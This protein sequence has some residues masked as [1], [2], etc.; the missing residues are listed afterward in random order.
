MLGLYSNVVPNI[1]FPPMGLEEELEC[2]NL[3]AWAE[4]ILALVVVFA[5]QVALS[6]AWPHSSR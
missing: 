6:V 5:Q 1:P 4:G 2:D 3:K